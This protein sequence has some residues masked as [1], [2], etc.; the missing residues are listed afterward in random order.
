[1]GSGEESKVPMAQNPYATPT[2]SLRCI[3][4]SR[5]LSPMTANVKEA[6]ASCQ[7]TN[8]KRPA[9]A[10]SNGTMIAQ[11]RKYATAPDANTKPIA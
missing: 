4:F 9:M 10:V 11:Q 7:V 2:I 1:M 8:H 6:I 5:R 3:A